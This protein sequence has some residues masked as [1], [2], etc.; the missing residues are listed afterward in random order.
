MEHKLQGFYKVL[1]VIG[2]GFLLLVVFDYSRVGQE[3]DDYLGIPVYYNGFFYEK[4]HGEN[5]SSEGYFYGLKWQCVEYVQRFYYE[6]L[7]HA[8]P[9]PR[10]NAR[11]FFDPETEQGQRNSVT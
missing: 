1:L 5:N 11:D 9:D 4:V 2:L 8:M 10:K 7:Q 3:I 6:H